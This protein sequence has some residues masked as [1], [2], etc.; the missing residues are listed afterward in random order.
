M[1]ADIPP[2]DLAGELPRGTVV[3]EASAGTGKTY[4]IAALA[5]R[6]VAEGRCRLPELLIVTFTRAATA[7]LR[8]R[9]R[10]RLTEAERHLADCLAGPVAD[11]DDPVLQRL[12]DA[13]AD[14]LEQRRKRLAQALTDFDAATISTIHGFTQQVLTSVGLSVDVPREITL[15]EDEQP[16]IEEVVDDVY[17]RRYLGRADLPARPTHGDV[18][19][20]AQL[21]A[22]HPDA[23]V[24]PES[25]HPG[26]AA[27]QTGEETGD[28][29]GD[30]IDPDGAEL[31]EA[32]AKA[33]ERAALAAE[34]RDAIAARKQADGLM[35]YDDLL[36]ALRRAL[37]DPTRG[38]QAR[39]VLRRRYRWA[40]VDEFQD[41]DP[42]Q[43]EILQ[44]AFSDTDD[45]TR[46]MVLIGDPKQ[47]IYSFRGADVRAYLAATKTAD[48]RFDLHTNY[49]TDQPLLQSIE[50]LLEDTRFGEHDIVFKHVEAPEQ[51]QNLQVQDDQDPVALQIR[52]H[53]D[54]KANA[55]DARRDIAGDL[56]ETLIDQLGRVTVGEPG[57]P[58]A[59]EDVAVLVRTNDEARLVQTTLRDAGIPS[60][61]NGVGSVLA[62]TAADDW[63]WL[64]D[65]L[66]RPNDPMRIR[67]LALSAW[68]GWRAP[69]LDEDNLDGLHDT[70]AGWSKILAN[71]GVATLEHA[72]LTDRQVATRLL[73]QT[74]GERH[75]TDLTHIG[76][77][78]HVAE[79]EED[80]GISGLRAWLQT[81]RAEA[82][83]TSTPSD[84]QAR[85]LE[86]DARAV[87]IV[88][89]HRSKGLQYPVVF[90]PF[91][92]STGQNT[93][94][95]VAVHDPAHSRRIV[96]VGP[97]GRTGADSSKRLAQREK[98][99]EQLRLVY[100]AVTRAQHRVVLWA[101]AKDTAKSALGRVLFRG[102]DGEVLLDAAPKAPEDE[103]A[104]LRERFAGTSTSVH[105]FDV[106]DG[107]E[108]P[109]WRDEHLNVTELAASSF[110]RTLDTRWRRTS[111]SAILRQVAYA[112]EH[113]A[114]TTGAAGTTGAVS[115]AGLPGTTG[116][117]GTTGA[118]GLPGTTGAVGAAGMPGAAGVQAAST[119]VATEPDDTVIEDEYDQQPT[120]LEALEALEAF[121]APVAEPVPLGSLRGGT[122]FGTLV[123]AV[124]EHL[125]FAADDLPSA[126]TEVI[127]EQRRWHRIDGIDDDAASQ[128]ADGLVDA[129]RTPLG[130][131]TELDPGSG[132]QT[133]LTDISRPD[134]LDEMDF[135]LPLAGGDDATG[136][137]TLARLADLLER[138]V[139]AG[140]LADDDPLREAG[141]PQRL[142]HPGFTNELRGYL[143]GSIDLLVR[144]QGHDGEPRYFI[145]DYKTNK[146][147]SGVP[148]VDDY[149]PDQLAEA[150]VHGDYPLQALLYQVAT[151]R[152]LRWRQPGYNPDVHLGGALYLY[153]RGMTG[154]TAEDGRPHGVFAWR[155]PTKLVTD[156]SDLLDGALPNGEAAADHD[157]ERS[158]R[159]DAGDDADRSGRTDAGD[160]S[161]RGGRTDAG[162]DSDRNE[163]ANS[164]E[165]PD[166][167]GDTDAVDEPTQEALW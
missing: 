90:V 55:A 33:A 164:G 98:M 20:L 41:T 54:N 43:W 125:D 28:G 108:L 135:E 95:P 140:G 50:R 131:L 156:L 158:D 77:L 138:P 88:T 148:T 62:T 44:D 126:L 23:E 80:R 160:D 124:F 74:G 27:E 37:R 72:V 53:P 146:L 153:V 133:R 39:Q 157:S 136:T 149:H 145:A 14:E 159:A 122:G 113:A 150:M 78:L 61:V 132:R 34:L 94:F 5:T 8:E 147:G 139:A 67:R 21:V 121:E 85:R 119:A 40:L 167:T 65:A 141:Y 117:A 101:G 110:E 42:V 109:R 142:R 66:E 24:I 52:L 76:R 30:T 97:S 83:D 111:Y 99:G 19:K 48:Q 68:I 12:G 45:P 11:T 17:V 47:A 166:R 18:T 134:R 129:I 2:L 104:A 144:L 56:A 7:E 16:L 86:S 13:S 63:R 71:K 102:E 51:H 84:E 79:R 107:R 4:A 3:L 49:R 92:Y 36:H 59:P 115:A 60:V 154:H 57:R 64:L 6:A 70:V 127:T 161:D 96:D 114:S 32:D 91:Q 58:L 151:H 130:P 93:T 38:E 105:T 25:D 152:F 128:L 89:V 82:G 137:A 22:R 69:D 155:P 1:S 163:R 100:V 29:I 9:I 118:A 46:A 120:L 103:A 143:N 123:H 165:G 75:L 15:L 10:R 73:S 116:T 81:A 106:D 35:T 87:Q 31:S 112:D 26:D 162:E